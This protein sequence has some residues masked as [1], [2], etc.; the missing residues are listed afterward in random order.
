MLVAQIIKKLVKRLR[1]S[2][3]G[4][5]SLATLAI[6]ALGTIGAFLAE[7]QVNSEFTNLGTSLWWT[8]VTMSTVG[9]GDIIPV[10][11]A[12]RV[13][14]SIC[15]IGGPVLMVSFVG[16]VGV[17]L[18]E[19]W[20]KGAKGMAQ[21]RSKGHIVICGW[22][23][24]AEEIISELR[25]SQMRELP[26][27][28]IDDRIESK[29]VDTGGITFVKGNPSEL[30]VLN[31]ANVDKAAFA[32]ILSENG[33]PAADQ[34]TVLT[35]LAIKKSNKSTVV[36]AEVNDPDNEDYLK[37]AG[38]EI[39]IDTRSLSSRLLA[40]SLQN[41]AVNDIVTELVSQAGN[42]IYPEPVPARYVG[43][44]FIEAFSELKKL[45]EGILVGIEREGKVMV[46]P[47]AAEV[48]NDGDILLIVSLEPPS[49]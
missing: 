28:I 16:A 22:K 38:C 21:I 12:G 30:R 43:R 14:G 17:R 2:S 23:R 36:C 11:T 3:A 26:I 18:Y 29:P 49:L 34:K 5:L 8:L 25:L 35:T 47:S 31:R 19:T 1:K 20:T 46:N 27:T 37:A 44:Q 40:M 7:R 42:E 4:I 48:I 39:I 41:P 32:I 6:V 9:Y 15:M 10:T 33:M 13:I 45:S 24:S